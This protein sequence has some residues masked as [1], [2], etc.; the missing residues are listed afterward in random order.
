[1]GADLQCDALTCREPRVVLA[2]AMTAIGAAISLG[3]NDILYRSLRDRAMMVGGGAGLKR[4]RSFLPTNN[5][6]PAHRQAALGAANSSLVVVG[7]PP[8]LPQHNH[9]IARFPLPGDAGWVGGSATEAVRAALRD[10]KLNTE[11]QQEEWEEE[12]RIGAPRHI[13]TSC[14]FTAGWE[15]G[16]PAGDEAEVGDRG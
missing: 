12:V 16:L 6:V 9:M 15:V 5:L 7:L 8:A 3:F 14:D 10:V 11:Q 1:M 2:V 4:Q 13:A